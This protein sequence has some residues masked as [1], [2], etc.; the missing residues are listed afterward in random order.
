M[1]KSLYN[2][3]EDQLILVNQLMESD[4]ELTPEL[5]Q[6]L[7]LNQK[8]LRQKSIAY[9][10]V[11]SSK[12]LRC[13]A[14]D[15]EIKRLQA[16]KKKEGKVVDKLK[17]SLLSAVKTFG[18]FEVGTVKFGTR[19]STSVEVDSDKINAL[20]DEFKTR[21]LTETANKKAIKEALLEGE[22]IEGCSLSENTNLKIN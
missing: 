21:K 3:N 15:S 12:D 4:G 14:I 9:L 8:N 22:K 1:S 10:E 6:Q 17:S 18:E 16:L 2:I 11:I 7:E 20:P 13:S 19:K 5:E